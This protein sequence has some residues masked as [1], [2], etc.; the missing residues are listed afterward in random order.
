SASDTGTNRGVD[1][2]VRI[3]KE[4]ATEHR[5]A[6]FRL[7]KI[8]SEIPVASLAS[9]VQGGATLKGLNGRPDADL[10]TLG[11]TH[12]TVAVMGTEPIQKALREGAE[13][14]I[15]GRASD[16]AIFAAPLLNAGYGPADAFYCGKAME[17]A[18]FCGEPFMGKETILGCV[19]EDGVYLTAMHPDQRCTPASV[20]GHA[21]Y[22]RLN[23]YREYVP[24]GY[25]DMSQ[26]RY[27]Q[28]AEKTTRVT[29]Q[30][31]VSDSR[32]WVKLEGSGKVAERALFILGIRD[33]YTI[34][35]LDRAI[36]WVKGKLTERFGPLGTGY[37]VHY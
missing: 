28:V 3:V 35:N 15:A 4:V 17:C 22:E 11:R 23:P 1:Q 31:F 13:V 12:H 37:D 18:S 33:P 27:E 30:T 21:M 5:L 16:P 32:T 9:R 6:P 25:L 14:V 19:Q 10:A 8:Y 29:G 7:A 36:E 20:A 24:G 2:F 34:A 26:C